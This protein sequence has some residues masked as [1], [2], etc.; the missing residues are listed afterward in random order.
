[1]SYSKKQDI[2]IEDGSVDSGN[3][4]SSCDDENAHSK[5]STRKFG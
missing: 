2:T 3:E 5:G 1:M 4:K